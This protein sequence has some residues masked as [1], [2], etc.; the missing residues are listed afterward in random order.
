[1]NKNRRTRIKGIITRM[2]GLA[3]ELEDVKFDEDLARD[4]TPENLQ[5]SDAYC[6]SEDCSDKIEDAISDIRQAV[7]TLE[8]I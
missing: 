7:S 2:N 1:M 8:E 5:G 4:N 6:D 3:D